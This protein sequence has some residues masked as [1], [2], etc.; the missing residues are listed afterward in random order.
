ME[1]NQ[2]FKKIIYVV[3]KTEREKI[4][5]RIN[6]RC[7][8][9]INLGVLEEVK[10]FLEIKQK[11]DHPI[12]KSIGLRQITRYL[13]GSKFFRR[14]NDGFYARNKKVCKKTIDLV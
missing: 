3:V 2:I 5:S 13:K 4:Y 14:N 10:S 9:M 1:K 8:E 12:H 7:E 11:L 6:S